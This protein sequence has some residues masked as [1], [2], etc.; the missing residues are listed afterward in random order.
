[1]TLPKIIMIILIDGNNSFIGFLFGL[2]LFMI[3]LYFIN[4]DLYKIYFTEMTAKILKDK[5][6]FF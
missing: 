5:F 1:M 6:E 3:Y 2:L 4:F